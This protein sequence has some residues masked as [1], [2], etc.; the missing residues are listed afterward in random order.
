M[1]PV[2]DELDEIYAPMES[3]APVVQKVQKV[4]PSVAILPRSQPPKTLSTTASND[5]VDKENLKKKG[6]YIDMKTLTTGAK[7]EG[8]V[9]SIAP[10]AAFVDV[11]VYRD[12]S[13]GSTLKVNG[14]LHKVDLNEHF[15]LPSN[16]TGLK[17]HACQTVQKG[18]NLTVYVKEVFKNSGYFI[19]YTVSLYP[20]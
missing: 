1:Y 12:A 14:M 7:L 2:F 16:D 17:S 19:Q 3:K 20:R 10:Y 6:Q 11:E 9:A 5:M 13:K 4:V 8:V 18:M 15:R